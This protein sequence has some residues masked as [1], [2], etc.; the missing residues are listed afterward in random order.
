MF[1]LNLTRARERLAELDH[2]LNRG[3]WDRWPAT[4]QAIPAGRQ[5]STAR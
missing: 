3:L 4:G 1:N 2:D 5:R